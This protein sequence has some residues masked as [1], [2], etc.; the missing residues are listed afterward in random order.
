MKTSSATLTAFY[1]NE[2][3]RL[4]SVC[5]TISNQMLIFFKFLPFQQVY[6]TSWNHSPP[7]SGGRQRGP[8]S[9]ISECKRHQVAFLKTAK[10]CFMRQT[11]L[12]FGE[13]IIKT[14]QNM[15]IL[16]YWISNEFDSTRHL[17]MF[18]FRP[19]R[20]VSRVKIK[21]Q[22]HANPS[23]CCELNVLMIPRTN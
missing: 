6:K 4:S 22:H 17:L 15:E 13:I 5:Q 18:A 9:G 23:R 1:K 12:L 20:K 2:H 8:I 11:P 16:W 21:W 10:E 3:W 19:N 7:R 14:N